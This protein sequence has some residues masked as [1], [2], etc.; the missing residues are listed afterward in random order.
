MIQ[1]K[2]RALAV[3]LAVMVSAMSVLML[4]IGFPAGGAVDQNGAVDQ[5]KA[6]QP[7]AQTKFDWRLT[8]RGAR[9]PDWPPRTG[10]VLISFRCCTESCGEMVNHFC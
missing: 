8:V 9:S 3:M 5:K 4:A 2:S 1:R 7:T 6:Q 10:S